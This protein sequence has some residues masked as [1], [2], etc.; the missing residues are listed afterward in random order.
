[1]FVVAHGGGFILGD[2]DSEDILCR[3]VAEHSKTAFVSIDYRLSPEVKAPVHIDD[4]WKVYK[5]VRV[6]EDMLQDLYTD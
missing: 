1:M 2:L 4:C 5:W 6:F 3:M